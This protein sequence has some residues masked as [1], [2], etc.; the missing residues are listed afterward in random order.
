[1]DRQRFLVAIGA[2]DFAAG[3]GAE[4]LED[5]EIDGFLDEANAAVTHKEVGSA[6][7]GAAEG[8]DVRLEFRSGE[9]VGAR[10]LKVDLHGGAAE[11]FVHAV[12]AVDAVRTELPDGFS[13]GNT[14]KVE[15]ADVIAGL[16]LVVF[17]ANEDC[18]RETIGE[19]LS[20]EA[21]TVSGVRV[22]DRTFKLE[23]AVGLVHVGVDVQ[24][25]DRSNGV[26]GPSAVGPGAGGVVDGNALLSDP[27]FIA[28]CVDVLGQGGGWAAKDAHRGFASRDAPLGRGA[29]R[30]A[31]ATFNVD[32]GVGESGIRRGPVAVGP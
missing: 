3:A 6:G 16:Q 9:N 27:V 13:A 30:A 4:G 12:L 2:D 31:G 10:G 25:N 22:V 17:F 11:R 7:V 21:G 26:R 8:S 14:L 29:G 5:V 24:L 1:M 28:G 20:L 15:F 32:A 19:A 18:V 23:R